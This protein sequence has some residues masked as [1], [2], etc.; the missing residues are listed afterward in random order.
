MRRSIIENTDQWRID[1]FGNGIA[2][3]MLNKITGFDK[4][5]QGDDAL[6]FRKDY[7]ELVEAHVNPNSAWYEKTFNEVLA[8]L[9]ERIN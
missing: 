2:Y 3:T 5:I 6:A 8:E 7:D 9:Y 4:C 1:S